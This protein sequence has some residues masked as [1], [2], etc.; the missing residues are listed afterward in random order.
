MVVAVIVLLMPV[1]ATIMIMTGP[2]LRAIL[3]LG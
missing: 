1:G 3:R 2:L